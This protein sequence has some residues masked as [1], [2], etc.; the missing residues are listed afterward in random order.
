MYFTLG[1]NYFHVSRMYDF[2]S[3]VFAI[4][5]IIEHSI[6]GNVSTLLYVSTNTQSSWKGG[7]VGHGIGITQLNIVFFSSLYKRSDHKTSWQRARAGR[8]IRRSG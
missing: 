1:H 6:I 7:G 8:N 5:I 3:V 4:K 2:F